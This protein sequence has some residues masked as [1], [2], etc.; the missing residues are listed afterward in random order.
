M[1]VQSDGSPAGDIIRGCCTAKLSVA[2]T[3]NTRAD[4]RCHFINAQ[5]SLFAANQSDVLIRHR[6]YDNAFRVKF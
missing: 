3:V 5:F 1:D 6:Y 2:V 4:A